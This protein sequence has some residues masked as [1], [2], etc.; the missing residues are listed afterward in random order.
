MNLLEVQR[1]CVKGDVF[2]VL[3]CL[4]GPDYSGDLLSREKLNRPIVQVYQRHPGTQLPEAAHLIQVFTAP[5]ICIHICANTLTNDGD[6]NLAT[7]FFF[8]ILG[9]GVQS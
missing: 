2:P 6:R 8:F 9:K 5:K 4:Q 1:Q 3:F 7:I